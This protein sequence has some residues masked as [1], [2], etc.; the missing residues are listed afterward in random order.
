MKKI[1]YLLFVVILF[2]G[3]Q[4]R[5]LGKFPIPDDLRPI[6][7][8]RDT[9]CYKDSM[10]NKIDTF[11]IKVFDYFRT[12]D[13]SGDYEDISINYNKKTR[14]LHYILFKVNLIC[15]LRYMVIILNTQH[16]I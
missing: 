8:D 1:F 12:V 13:E 6:L 9:L 11:V 16:L 2:G 7:K 5:Y 3:C 14:Y 15:M 10:T 4:L